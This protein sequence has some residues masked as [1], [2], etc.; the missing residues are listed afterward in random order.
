MLNGKFP[1]KFKVKVKACEHGGLAVFFFVCP[2][3]LPYLMPW[4]GPLLLTHL[5][6]STLIP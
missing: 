5:V 6:I 4:F 2:S 3:L 1:A